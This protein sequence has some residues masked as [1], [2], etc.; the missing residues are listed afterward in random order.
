MA[1]GARCKT[2]FC[3]ETMKHP[4]F[5]K[6][7]WPRLKKLVFCKLSGL[8]N[9]KVARLLKFVLKSFDLVLRKCLPIGSKKTDFL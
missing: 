8:K 9:E 5:A 6:Q 7:K 4:V 2:Q 1:G 3:N